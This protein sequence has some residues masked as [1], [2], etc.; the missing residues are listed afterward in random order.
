MHEDDYDPK[1]DTVSR[2]M[3]ES[4]LH[5]GVTLDIGGN[6]GDN[7]FDPKHYLDVTDRDGAPV[8]LGLLAGHTYLREQ[9]PNHN[10]YKAVDALALKTM[11]KACASLLD[12]GCLGISFGVKYVPGTTPEELSALAS[13]CQKGDKLVAS[14]VRQDLDEVFAAADELAT[15]SQAC[16]V[17]VQFSHIGSMGATV[18]CLACLRTSKITAQRVSICFATAIHTTLSVPASAK[19]P[20]T[21][22]F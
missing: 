4:A 1:T 7:A 12:C 18:K 2:S 14:H 10:K 11:T 19:R 17:R 13:L 20:M 21:T 3:A 22:D 9:I 16:G 6:C 15:V 5:M 8:N